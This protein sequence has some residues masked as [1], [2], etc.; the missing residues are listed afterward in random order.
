VPIQSC[1]LR[2]DRF[3]SGSIPCVYVPDL[4]GSQVHPHH[5]GFSSPL[6]NVYGGQQAEA[7]ADDKGAP[8]IGLIGPQL[9][10]IIARVKPTLSHP[11]V[12]L[13]AILRLYD[14]PGRAAT[15]LG[16]EVVAFSGARAS[17]RAG[18]LEGGPL[19]AVIA[20]RRLPPARK[21]APQN[22]NERCWQ[23]HS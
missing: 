12:V 17:G 20:G 8:A 11:V 21:A 4:S 5:D 13:P 1:L 18:F 16:R 23:S 9:P 19:L 3:G 14:S 10:A 2:P 15:V 22:G 6:L 7:V